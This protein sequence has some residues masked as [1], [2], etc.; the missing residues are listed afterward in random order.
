MLFRRDAVATIQS[1]PHSRLQPL[2][3]RL[4]TRG[5][6]I[7]FEQNRNY[8][9]HAAEAASSSRIEENR[10]TMPPR[11]AV[12]A[13]PRGVNSEE[14]TTFPPPVDHTHRRLTPSCSVPVVVVVGRDTC[15]RRRMNGGSQEAGNFP[16]SQ[17]PLI[18]HCVE[19]CEPTTTCPRADKTDLRVPPP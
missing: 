11:Q 9:H 17:M 8:L 10:F 18:I 19:E 1:Q 6:M 13:L 4:G 7:S 16:H 12:I 2:L 15:N 5:M 3:T 14:S